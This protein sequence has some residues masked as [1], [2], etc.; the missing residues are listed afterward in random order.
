MTP[1]STPTQTQQ[2]AVCPVCFATQAIRENGTMVQHGYTRPELWHQNVNTCAGTGRPHFGTEAGR[3][4]TQQCAADARAAADAKA[5]QATRVEDGQDPVFESR[6][7]R[8]GGQRVLVTERV[9]IPTA[10]QR[11][12]WV[13]ALRASAGMLTARAAELDAL[14]AAWTPREPITVAVEPKQALTH[15]RSPRYWRG[16]GK[17]CAGSMMGAQKGYSTTT[18]EDVT[19]EKCKARAARA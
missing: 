12:A 4:Y 15:W 16:S 8:M 1:T 5:A 3:A 14:A 18:F 13:R 10:R 19:C 11:E 17:A 6:T 7:T 9:E 2:R